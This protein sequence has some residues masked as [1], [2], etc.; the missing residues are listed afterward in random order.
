MGNR[1]LEVMFEYIYKPWLFQVNQ[2]QICTASKML[3][4]MDKGKK[5]R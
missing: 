1:T 2:N 5:I 3:N 4:I